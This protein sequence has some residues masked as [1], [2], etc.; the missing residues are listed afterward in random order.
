MPKLATPLTDIQPRN[1]KAK[2]KPYMLTDGGGLYLLVNPDGSKYWRMSYRLDGAKRTLAFGTYPNVSL[3]DARKQRE[4]ARGLIN[5]GI[6]PSQ[7]KRIDKELKKVAAANTFEAI[8]L[9]WHQHKI[10]TW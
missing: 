7:A 9:E 8:A 6:N 3:L 5:E 4:K 1:A 2:D 10:D